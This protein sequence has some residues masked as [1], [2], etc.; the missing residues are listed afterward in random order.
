MQDLDFT[1][2]RSYEGSQENG[3]EELVCQLAHLSPPTNADY[4]VRKRGAGGDAGVE[5]Y[6]KL[7]DGSEHGW[8][9]K[10]FLNSLE[11]SQWQQISD[12]I[13][14]ALEKHPKLTKYYVCLPRDWTDSR[15]KGKGG[16]KIKSAWDEW[17]SNVEKWKKV[18][19][20]KGM[21]VE[22]CY[23]CK[24]EICMQLQTDDPK[25]S[26]RALYWFNQAV[27][28]QETLKKIADKSRKSLGDRFTPEFHVELPVAE[29]LAGIGQTGNWNEKVNSINDRWERL[30]KDFQKDVASSDLIDLT[31]PLWKNFQNKISNFQLE[32]NDVLATSRFLEHSSTLRDLLVSLSETSS[33]C[34]HDI[35]NKTREG[36]YEDKYI[37]LSRKLYELSDEINSISNFFSSAVLNLATVQAGLML[38]EAG[39]GKSHLLC[40]V[41]FKRL[42]EKLPT[43]LLL[44]AHYGGGNP[45][46]FIRKTLD[47][48]SIS[49]GETLGALDALG[50]SCDSVTLILIDAINEGPHKEE[51]LDQLS[52]F[53][54]ELRDYQHISVLLSCRKTY[55]PFLIPEELEESY[56][57]KFQ[58][59]GFRGHEREAAKIYLEK[60]GISLLSVPIMLPEFTNPLFLKTCCQALRNNNQTAFPK[61]L[62]G[63]IS[64][65]E[66][67]LESISK[68]VNRKKQYRQQEDVLAQVITSLVKIL[69][70]E[71][72][73]GIPVRDARTLVTSYDINP[74]HGSNLFELLIEEGVLATDISYVSQENP[75]GEEIVRF[76]YERFS[77]FAIAKSILDACPVDEVASL[78]DPQQP[79]GDMLTAKDFYE[80]AGIIEALGVCIPERCGS[81][82]IDLV[83]GE[84]VPED[85]WLLENTFTKSILWRSPEAFSDRTLELLN[86]VPRSGSYWPSLDILI[87]LATEPGHPWNAEFLHE[88]LRNRNMPERDS[89]WSTHIAV[90]D[91]EESE[92]P[93]RSLINWSFEVEVDN[94]D[95]KRLEL[96]EVAICWFLTTPNRK[97]RDDATKSL[98]R[99]L[100]VAPELIVSLLEKFTEV[101]DLY[102]KERLYAAV[103]GAV[104]SVEDE[105][106]LSN[107]STSV[108][109]AVFKSE[110]PVPHLLFR[111]YAREI[112]EY[113]SSK[114]CLPGEIN[115]ASCRPPYKSDWPIE[116]PSEAEI[117]ELAGEGYQSSIKSSL[118]GFPGDFG[119]Y[120]M[121]CVHYWSPTS[122]SEAYPETSREANL[123]FASQL[124]GEL[125]EDYLTII[126]QEGQNEGIS[127][128]VQRL[129][130]LTAKDNRQDD[131]T[132]RE[133]F[134]KKLSENVEASTREYYRWVSGFGGVKS[135][136]T[137]SRKWAQR[138]VCRR[139][140]E[141]GWS[142]ELFSDFEVAHARHIDRSRRRIERIGKKYQW[143]AFYELLAR[144]ADNVHW[145]GPGYSNEADQ[146]YQ[147]PWQIHDRDIDPTV[148]IRSIKYSGTEESD[149]SAWWQKGEVSFADGDREGL[150]DWMLSRNNIPAFE[151]CIKFLDSASNEWMVLRGFLSVDKK[152][153]SDEG[154]LPTQTY[155][156]RINSVLIHEDD[157]EALKTRLEGKNLRSPDLLSVP[158]N[159]YQIFLREYPW[160]S[161]FEGRT[162]W[163]EANDIIN[164]RHLVNV[165]KYEWEAGERDHSIEKTISVFLP[166]IEMIN[167][168]KLSPLVENVG[169]WEN[170]FGEVTFLDPS[171][172]EQGP[173]YG[174]VR[175][176]PFQNWLK[177]EK[178]KLI[179]LVGGEK[180]LYLSLST[181][182]FGRL[183]F[184]GVYTLEE[185][186]DVNGKVWF[187]VEPEAQ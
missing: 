12:S 10:Y 155:W 113:I 79:I 177:K 178:L 88:D 29:Y 130:R 141:L 145:V 9:A 173:S 39:I 71:N 129:Q 22:F 27:I 32:L 123:K 20:D 139:C 158:N 59:F 81:E 91:E 36:E 77:D 52:G 115:L 1:Q 167:S 127:S 147:G 109:D 175:S 161:Y 73:P 16:G 23:W 18:A 86:E 42:E 125:K 72:L 66:Y 58:H 96:A 144:L 25:F 152:M 151:K 2:I 98:A 90:G 83:C 170:E 45:I 162:N 165:N 103:Y 174:L 180:Y 57:V 7:A 126:E 49:N 116:N 76:T 28:R 67:Y 43:V 106:I 108:Y 5:C 166:T 117:D 11:S 184:S 44:G 111:D 8:Q 105:K 120:T 54:H 35:Y 102:L 163:S 146:T 69:F 138:W 154:V 62:D 182:F 85:F 95:I 183:N 3:F 64:L 187:E 186:G 97:V 38:G 94:V 41:T 78:F 133:V 114:G 17:C 132:P 65:F 164:V 160:H 21:E 89:F 84:V 136:A 119:R 60:N 179:W 26:G 107:I 48:P 87:S 172:V 124:P 122:L 143:I 46:D 112:L 153:D 110:T 159:E 156:H 4:F 31:E 68:I 157:I 128:L 176:E 6:W 15:K 168:M 51:W 55:E 137:F 19:S 149:L 171:V 140:Y 14:S 169:A 34:H 61:G 93:L 33:K 37:P 56:L 134:E 131:P 100:S 80:F 104:F 92:A 135:K 74:N 30:N 121:S 99:L 70:P 82:F 101:D 47:L 75:R 142:E 53:L 181:S 148:P 50:E 185:G 24:H 13:E 118:Y 150:K 63:I 40:D